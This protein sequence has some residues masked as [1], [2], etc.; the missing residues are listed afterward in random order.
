M[1]HTISLTFVCVYCVDRE[2]V[3]SFNQ[4]NKSQPNGQSLLAK[5][6]RYSVMLSRLAGVVTREKGNVCNTQYAWLDCLDLV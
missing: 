2:V 5:A 3:L 4:K 6:F 1:L